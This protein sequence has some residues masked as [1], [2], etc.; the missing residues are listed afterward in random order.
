[1]ADSI[2]DR[3]RTDNRICDE[4]ADFRDD[5]IA[6]ARNLEFVARATFWGPPKTE[7]AIAIDLSSRRSSD[8]TTGTTAVARSAADTIRVWEVNRPRSVA[9]VRPRLGRS[10][11]K[12][13]HDK[14]SRLPRAA[15]G[16]DGDPCPRIKTRATRHRHHRA[17]ARC[18]G[19]GFAQRSAPASLHHRQDR[20]RQ[21]DTAAQ[22]DACRSAEPAA[23]SPCSIRTAIW[24]WRSPMRR[25]PGAL[26]HGVIYLDPSDLAHPGR[27]QSPL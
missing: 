2:G 1:M 15:I 11:H 4:L 27:L 6:I 23:A 22:P 12:Q 25:R 18:A 5:A 16:S 14:A 20:H 21:V 19:C 13:C 7:S 10:T 8:S 9:A 3:I 17:R 24:R 26:P